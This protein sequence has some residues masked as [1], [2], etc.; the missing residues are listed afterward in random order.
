MSIC[1]PPRRT[2]NKISNTN[3]NATTNSMIT[4]DNIRLSND[5]VARILSY[6][7]SMIDVLISNKTWHVNKFWDGQR[8]NKLHALAHEP[9]A[10]ALWACQNYS[11]NA[12]C[13]CQGYMPL[14]TKVG[15]TLNLHKMKKCSSI[16]TGP[17]KQQHPCP[18]WA[19]LMCQG[20]TPILLEEKNIYIYISHTHIP[21]TLWISASY[22]FTT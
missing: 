5:H 2:S 12:K 11:C 6:D 7:R 16:A 10:M 9:W 3:N 19:L 17:P 8:Y 22:W 4:H 18:D 13:T 15:P 14:G 21:P 20:C 1:Y